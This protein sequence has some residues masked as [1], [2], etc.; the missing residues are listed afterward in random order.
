MWYDRTLASAKWEDGRPLRAVLYLRVSTPKQIE[1]GCGSRS[2]GAGSPGARES[3]PAA[4]RQ[5]SL[6]QKGS[7][8]AIC[9]DAVARRI[10]LGRWCTYRC[11][12][13]RCGMGRAGSCR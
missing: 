13:C 2:S 5:R 10:L 11:L 7:S 3:L 4:A 1:E 8:V 12:E 9:T 6:L